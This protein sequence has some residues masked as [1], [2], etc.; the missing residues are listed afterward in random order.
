MH[1]GLCAP[2]RRAALARA[3]RPYSCYSDEHQLAIVLALAGRSEETDCAGRLCHVEFPPKGGPHPREFLPH[4]VT[5]A[6]LRALRRPRQCD[7]A[8]AIMCAAPCPHDCGSLGRGV[9]EWD[10]A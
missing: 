9:L 8:A 2:P 4:E 10:V 5:P 7:A 6:R 1:T 3:R